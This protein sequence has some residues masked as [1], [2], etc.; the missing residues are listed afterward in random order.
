M[1]LFNTLPDELMRNIYTFIN[2]INEYTKYVKALD[3]YNTLTE[4]ASQLYQDFDE[5][6]PACD[7]DET[8]NYITCSASI[9]CLLLENLQ[10]VSEFLKK[11]PKFQRPKKYNL[12]RDFQYKK[13][14]EHSLSRVQA[15]RL[16]RNINNRRGVWIKLNRGDEL[17]MYHKIDYI[18]QNGT[19][20]DLIYACIINNVKGFKTALRDY[21]LKKLYINMDIQPLE[22]KYI[23]RFV[24][25]YYSTLSLKN[26][27]DSERKYIP[28]KN[29]LIRRLMAL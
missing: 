2:P 21:A 29:T 19:T 28:K 4:D 3:S 22:D 20:A 18:L 6:S 8:I 26:Y 16:E 23:A 7:M 25:Y 5:M 11:N 15:Y 12:L 27:S 10:D 13:H 17:I 9:S 24:N 14:M 1:S